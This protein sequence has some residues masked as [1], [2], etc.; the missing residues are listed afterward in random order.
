MK[1][2]WLVA[3]L[4]L[5]S[6][7]LVSG[8]S[9]PTSEVEVLDIGPIPEA[10]YTDISTEIE[11]EIE[12]HG[13]E[14]VLLLLPSGWTVHGDQIDGAR[15][16]RIL[17]TYL[18][19]RARYGDPDDK[20]SFIN[21]YYV[22]TSKYTVNRGGSQAWTE[23]G[24]GISARGW[25]IRPNERL[26]I[27]IKL[28]PTGTGI[29]DPF[30]IEEKLPYIKV[31]KWYQEF[32]LTTPNTTGFI[33]APFVV[34]NATLIEAYPAIFGNARD[35]EA[36]E[37][38]WEELK[39]EEEEEEVIVVNWDEWFS[40]TSIPLTSIQLAS[41]ELEYYPIGKVE[42]KEEIFV[43]MWRIVIGEP[44]IRYTYEWRRGREIRGVV[45]SH[46]EKGEIEPVVPEW[47]E[48]F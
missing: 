20:Y 4:V 3:L 23:V 36:G 42:K 21:T 33:S 8:I 15:G 47:D 37:Y 32:K 16:E 11:A 39:V 26:T 30:S 2:I 46:F 14:N 28:V 10:S 13:Y 7:T 41:T 5:M 1:K 44:F 17:W 29:I 6:F 19:M 25:Y 43:P 22:F 45:F 27:H 34:K 31:T 38:Y 35:F 12:N 40:T 24:T 48:W 18:D 9:V